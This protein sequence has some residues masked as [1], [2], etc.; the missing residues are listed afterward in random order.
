VHTLW[1]L[2]SFW[3]FFPIS[4][5]VNFF[6]TDSD[7]SGFISKDEVFVVVNAFIKLAD[8]ACQE[9]PMRDRLKDIVDGFFR[10]FDS[11]GNGVIESFELNEIVSDFISGITT[12]ITTVIDY[13]EPHFL[14]VMPPPPPTPP[15]P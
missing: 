7:G 4:D 2:I 12:I 15:P 14:K 13:L 8:P 9:L 1:D 6:F 5:R 10:V 11:N 3:L